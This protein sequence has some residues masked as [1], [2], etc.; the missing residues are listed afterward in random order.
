MVLQ[1]LMQIRHLLWNLITQRYASSEL[2]F[3]NDDSWNQALWR[4]A[5]ANTASLKH[6]DALRDWKTYLQKHPAD[7]TARLRLE[8]CQKIIKRDAFLKAIEVPDD[9]SAA[10]GLD[11]EHMA[12]DKDYDGM[13]LGETITLEFIEDMIERFRTEKKIHKKYVFQII[14]AVKEIV[15]NE[16][17]MVEM[18]VPEGHT[19]TVCGDTHGTS[20]PFSHLKY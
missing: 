4:R 12:V 5:V 10:D 1:S 11:L 9:A 16:P 2:R 8:D 14:L 19:L 3:Y 13:A 17:T 20:S 15:Y 6:R 18:T 7:S